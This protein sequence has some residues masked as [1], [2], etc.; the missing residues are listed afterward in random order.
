VLAD[1]GHNI[2]ALS[3]VIHHLRGLNYRTIHFILGF[4]KGK[5]VVGI[6]SQLNVSDAIYLTSPSMDRGIPTEELKQMAIDQGLTSIIYPNVRE[7]LEEVIKLAHNEDLIYVGG[8]SF[9]VADLLTYYDEQSD[10]GSD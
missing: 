4:V 6:L 1:S 8:S 2:D 9:V 5:D 7:A 3:K 10:I